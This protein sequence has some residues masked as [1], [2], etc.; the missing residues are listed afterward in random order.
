VEALPDLGIV[1]S[2]HRALTDSGLK[3]KKYGDQRLT[4]ADANGLVIMAQRHINL[5]WS[6][7]RHLGLGGASLVI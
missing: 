5:C 4:L 1:P 6:T 2:D 7:D 3:V